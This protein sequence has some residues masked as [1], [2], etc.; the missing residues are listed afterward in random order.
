MVSQ[1]PL[2]TIRKLYG[3]YVWE[4]DLLSIY[5]QVRS[6]RNHKHNLIAWKKFFKEN[7]ETMYLDT[8]LPRKVVF[9]F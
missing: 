1:E 4:Q 7:F 5:N 9:P 8:K 2:G 3:V 6:L